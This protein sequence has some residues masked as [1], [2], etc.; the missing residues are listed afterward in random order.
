MTSITFEELA[1]LRSENNS[2]ERADGII[3]AIDDQ[4]A[5]VLDARA[6][7][8]DLGTVCRIAIPVLDLLRALC[9]LAP[10]TQQYH[11][12][13]NRSGCNCGCK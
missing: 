7:G 13:D 5:Q 11:V 8:V 10:S 9:S 12:Q 6:A 2:S 4:W 1:R 3:E